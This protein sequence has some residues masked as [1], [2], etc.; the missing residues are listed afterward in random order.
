MRLIFLSFS[1]LLCSCANTVTNLPDAKHQ[2]AQNSGYVL[3]PVFRNINVHEISITGPTNFQISKSDLIEQERY[4]LI[5]LPAGNYRYDDIVIYKY[6]IEHDFDADLWDFNVQ[7]NAINYIGHLKIKNLG[8]LRVHLE[9]QNNSSV[10]LEY[11]EENYPQLMS[12][13]PLIY[14][15]MGNDDFLSSLENAAPN[16]ESDN[17]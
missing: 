8:F 3:L 17:E 16:Q 15:G 11:L 2:R 12:Q 4:M 5:E 10:A 9:I 14:S 6:F 13:Y 1:L 7:P